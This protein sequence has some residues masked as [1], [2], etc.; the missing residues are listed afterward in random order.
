MLAVVTTRTFVRAE[1]FAGC[2]GTDLDGADMGVRHGRAVGAYDCHVFSD[3]AQQNRYI[4]DAKLALDQCL[5]H[6]RIHYPQKWL[7]GYVVSR[8]CTA[9]GG[10]DCA[11]HCPH[12]AC[13]GPTQLAPVGRGKG[14]KPNP[15]CATT[16][17]SLVATSAFINQTIMVEPAAVATFK[18]GNMNWSAPSASWRCGLVSEADPA[19]YVGAFL[20]ARGPSA[21][22][23]V[24]VQPLFLLDYYS[25]FASLRLEP[26]LPSGPAF[27]IAEGVFERRFSSLLVRF[28]CNH[29]NASFTGL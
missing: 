12:G 1:M 7:T 19:P 29:F 11:F 28:D 27:E 18:C 25:R 23:Q 4:A 6:Y 14:I 2:R 20:V 15:L 26:G 21:V 8:S 24:T 5:A 10:V 3:E 9:H 17:R 16:M 22:F 13:A